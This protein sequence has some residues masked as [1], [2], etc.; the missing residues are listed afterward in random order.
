MQF[1][2]T[3]RSW[4]SKY[5]IWSLFSDFFFIIG[6]FLFDW[7][8]VL[9]ILWFMV[10]SSAMIFFGIILFKKEGND[11]VTTIGFSISSFLIICMLAGLYSGVESF[12]EDL[13]MEDMIKTDPS[14]IL[15]PVILPIVLC[16]SILNHHSHYIEELIRMNNGTYN[17]T[18][19]KHFYLRYILISALILFIIF[20]FVYF[21]IGIVIALIGIKAL[22]RIFNKKLRNVL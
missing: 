1:Y 12:I 4:N 22:L 9:L 5:D 20:F 14:Q 16:C 3:I 2:N 6:V 11:W 18:Y 10:D 8:P 21:E 7:N 19:I 13:N 17:S 15:N